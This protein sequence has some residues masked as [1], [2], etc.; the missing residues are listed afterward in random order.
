MIH[1]RSVPST[2]L[3]GGKAWGNNEK[4]LVLKDPC[5]RCKLAEV[6]DSVQDPDLGK[7]VAGE[8]MS[9]RVCVPCGDVLRRTIA[10]EAEVESWQ[11]EGGS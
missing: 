4:R 7:D 5:E 9:H 10:M 11:E 3:S 6:N 2:I 8:W 1:M